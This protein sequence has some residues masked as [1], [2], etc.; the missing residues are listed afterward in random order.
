MR[1]CRTPTLL[2][3]RV[4]RLAAVI[5][6]LA[7]EANL[8][9]DRAAGVA[10]EVLVQA[11]YPHRPASAH[12]DREQPAGVEHAMLPVAQAADLDRESARRSLHERLDAVVGAHTERAS[13]TPRE[14]RTVRAMIAA[15]TAWR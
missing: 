7:G 8:D 1:S 10:S 3:F 2:L 4:S 11:T 13:W 15:S 6:L 12:P 9:V 5:W 14:D